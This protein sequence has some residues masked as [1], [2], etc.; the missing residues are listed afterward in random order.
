[1]TDTGT[2]FYLQGD[3]VEF[4]EQKRI[5]TGAC[6]EVKSRK[7]EVLIETS[8]H[9]NLSSNR[10]IHRTIS[11][12]SPQLANP[13][14]IRFLRE[15]GLERENIR[16]TIDLKELWQIVDNPGSEITLKDLSE[17]SYDPQMH[18]ANFV[19]YEAALNRA[20]F[21]DK[22]YFVIKSNYIQI[23]TPEN[24]DIALE[25]LNK[26]KAREQEKELLAVW[27]KAKSRK[28]EISPP[29]GYLRLL[30]ALKQMAAGT[31]DQPDRIWAK[32]ILQESGTG[33]PD[34]VLNLLIKMGL[35]D[36]D[37]NLEITK[38]SLRSDHSEQCLTEVEELKHNQDLF[39]DPNR[40]DL[41]HLAAFTIDSEETRDMDDALSIRRLDDGTVEVGV[42]ITDV[43]A[44]VNPG[45]F[46]DD[47]AREQTQTLYLPDKI[48]PMF[49]TE[50]SENIASLQAHEPR[51]AISTIIRFAPDHSLLDYAIN[52]SIIKVHHR[53][54]YDYIDSIISN[55]ELD[56]MLQI[57]SNLR[58]IRIDQGAMIIPRPELLIRVDEQ[59][60]ITLI[61]R[62][63][64]TSSQIIVS[65]FMIL[66]NRL[67]AETAVSCGI[68]FPFRFQD[69]PAEK[70]PTSPK[71]FDPYIAYCQRRLMN[72]AGTS[73]QQRHHYSLGLSAYTN[74]TSPLRRYFDL[75]AQRQ[76]KAAIGLE[77]PYDD[78]EL[79][80]II[81]EIDSASAKAIAVSNERH[82]YWLLKYL[83]KKQGQ[84]LSAVVLDK[85]PRRFQI[86][87]N[88]YYINA[89]IPIP[90]GIN[91]TP[92]QKINVILE[93]TQPREKNLVLRLQE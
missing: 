62:E 48:I 13:E 51:L 79:R 71:V 33:N 12:I 55:P 82:R 21:L 61:N 53:Y 18:G 15:L 32:E 30:K 8:R 43:A 27:L 89:D 34:N 83:S 73:I 65:E 68:P 72:R 49:P 2:K 37:E 85:F 22:V 59:K 44:F 60:N 19:N 70:P 9:M 86:W 47:E 56:L 40:I 7:L 80:N 16:K 20:I 52:A 81:Y 36:P 3:I 24:I 46:L 66:A 17:L 29:P 28:Q 74:V 38:H 91:L 42:H 87:L 25:K 77:E 69:A 6:M 4:F 14:I 63:R 90:F 58:Q 11:G 10:V 45:S 64:E 23:Q 67:A 75:I 41:Q 31:Q 78:D 39:H 93:R 88:D 92:N 84:I 76:L 35:I 5:L 1:M 57:A 50:F 26:L 54:S